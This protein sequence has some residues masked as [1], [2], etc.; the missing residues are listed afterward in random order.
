MKAIGVSRSTAIRACSICL[1][2]V[3][4]T[5]GTGKALGQSEFT[6]ALEGSFFAPAMA[7]VVAHCLPWLEITVGMLLILGVLPRIVSALSV[8]MISGF[9]ASNIWLLVSRPAAA[10]ACGDCFG[11]WERILGSLSPV[12]ALLVDLFLLGLAVV[13]L[14]RSLI[15]T[16]PFQFPAQG[17][18]T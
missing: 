8:G 12:Q 3:F 10:I 4:L 11:V 17:D 2:L 18:G 6:H 1:G 13:L 14:S 5:A 15:V 16:R 7:S 9:V